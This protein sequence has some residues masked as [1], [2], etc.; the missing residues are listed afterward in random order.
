MRYK[1]ILCFSA[2]IEKV[3]S[4]NDSLEDN[5]FGY[6][7]RLKRIEQIKKRQ[8]D[9]FVA[10]I[11]EPLTGRDSIFSVLIRSG[12]SARALGYVLP[13]DV[14]QE[15]AFACANVRK[16][17]QHKQVVALRLADIFTE[18]KAGISDY[19]M[20]HIAH[21]T[22]TRYL[23]WMKT[24]EKILGALAGMNGSLP[25][26]LQGP[27]TYLLTNEWNSIVGALETT[28]RED[29]EM[30]KFLELSRKS[31][32]YGITIDFSS[33]V[34]ILEKL[35]TEEIEKLRRALSAEACN[36]IRYLLNFVDRF[37]IPIAKH[38]IE[39]A[40]YPLL[41]TSIA[42]LYGEYKSAQSPRA[43]QKNFLL[44]LLGFAR[45]MNFSTSRF[46]LD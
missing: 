7:I 28:G 40:F 38:K 23:S 44:H 34:S 14:V 6:C 16:W 24:N 9:A 4:A 46:A 25:P 27:V 19:F 2:A 26:F 12:Y 39:D 41:N 31:R 36:R 11:T 35:L 42:R 33:S 29:A 10:T 45:R 13:F 1:E 22:R 21:S 18:S 15:S 43:E 20:Q 17:M 37:S 3:I 8:S 5:R 30:V 32:S